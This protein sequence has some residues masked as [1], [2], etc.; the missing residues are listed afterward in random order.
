MGLIEGIGRMAI[1]VGTVLLNAS[2]PAAAGEAGRHDV[3]PTGS[4]SRPRTLPGATAE[5]Q[6][7]DGNDTM[8]VPTS[9]GVDASATIE[10]HCPMQ[11]SVDGAGNFINLGAG[12]TGMALTF[13]DQSLLDFTKITMQASREMLRNSGQPAPDWLGYELR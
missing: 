7:R 3:G 6:S 9:L 5:H 2:Q 10:D 12:N 11:Y 13:T 1:D 4:A 8:Y